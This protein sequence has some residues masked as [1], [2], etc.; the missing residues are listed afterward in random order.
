M[1]QT[2]KFC[3]RSSVNYGNIQPANAPQY[4]IA[5][6]QQQRHPQLI[7]SPMALE[8]SRHIQQPSVQAPQQAHS[9]SFLIVPI[10]VDAQLLNAL[11]NSNLHPPIMQNGEP[12][13]QVHAANNALNRPFVR[14]QQQQLPPLLPL[15]QDLDLHSYLFAARNNQLQHNHNCMRNHVSNGNITRCNPSS[16]LSASSVSASSSSSSNSVAPISADMERDSAIKQRRSPVKQ[17]R[18]PAVPLAAIKQEPMA[19]DL[20]LRDIPVLGA[21]PASSSQPASPHGPNGK[22]EEEG[23]DDEDEDKEQDDDVAAVPPAPSGEA[24]DARKKHKCSQCEKTF[25]REVNLIAHETVHTESAFQ[26]QYCL[27]KFARRSNLQQHIR[28]HTELRIMNCPFCPRTFQQKHAL[29]S[30]IR[31]HTGEKPFVCNICHWQFAAKCN[32]NVHMRT[33][34]GAKP[35]HCKQCDKRYASKSGFNAHRKKFHSDH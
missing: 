33:H 19:M 13:A 34:T 29:C 6:Q 32:L 17:E 20:A 15:Q 31:T 4:G 1:L 12:A 8:R 27:K 26:C 23:D 16:A 24:R 3:N 2:N 28:V 30:H 9:Q 22:E 11:C 25:I 35:Y 5:Q 14:R 10:S 7:M 18:Q 21:L